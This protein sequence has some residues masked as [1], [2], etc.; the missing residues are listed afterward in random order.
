MLVGAT[1]ATMQAIS[2]LYLPN[3][4]GRASEL[5]GA[6]GTTV[7]TLGWFFFLGRAIVLAMAIDAVLYERFGSITAFV[8]GLPVLRILPRHSTLI[9]RVFDLDV[10][11]RTARTRAVRRCA[12]LSSMTLPIARATAEQYELRAREIE[13]S[14]VPALLKIAGGDRVGRLGDRHH[15]CRDAVAGLR[16]APVRRQRRPPPFAEWVYRTSESLM[17]PF[18]GIF[19]P[20]Q[21]SDTSIFD[22]SLLFGAII[23]LIVALAVRRPGALVREQAA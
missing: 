14:P 21:I 2:Q 10:E 17:R 18:R 16:P 6:I 23:Y 15:E 9:R 12:N 20:H 5:Y 11:P 8:F 19:P 13:D 22:A 7:V 1:I 4:M 3:R